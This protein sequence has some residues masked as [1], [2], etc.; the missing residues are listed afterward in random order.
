MTRN[1]KLRKQRNF[2][3]KTR[4]KLTV[5]FL[6]VTTGIPSQG[7]SNPPTVP[8]NRVL[9][10]AINISPGECNGQKITEY[11][12]VF[13]FYTIFSIIYSK[14]LKFFTYRQKIHIGCRGLGPTLNA[15]TKKKIQ[16]SDAIFLG[17]FGFQNK[18]SFVLRFPIPFLKNSV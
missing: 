2:W 9:T 11:M 14:K 5:S 4:L 13:V 18:I 12:L 1:Q 15:C 8:E 3:N 6:S 16:C 17:L 10:R 7:K